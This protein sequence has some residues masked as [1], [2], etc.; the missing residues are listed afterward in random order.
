MSKQY[1]FLLIISIIVLG[2]IWYLSVKKDDFREEE[3]SLLHKKFLEERVNTCLQKNS[4]KGEKKS[5]QATSEVRK[6]CTKEAEEKW[7]EALILN[8]ED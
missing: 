6:E 3:L 5:S 7:E 4:V 8:N 1:R 2:T